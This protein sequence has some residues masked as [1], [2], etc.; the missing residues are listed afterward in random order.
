MVELAAISRGYLSSRPIEAARVL[1]RLDA[2]EVAAF[3]AAVPAP[4]AAAPLAHMAPWKVARCLSQMAPATAAE[5]LARLPA[6]HGVRSLRSLPES[7]REAV[8]DQLPRRRARQ[9]RRQLSY[10]ASLVGAW[11]AGH[12]IALEPEA[13]VGDALAALKGRDEPGRVNV[14]MTGAAGQPIGLVPVAGVLQVPPEQ[15]LA[16]VMRRDIAP[17]PA[18]APLFRFDADR[19][20]RGLLERP[21]VDG[22]GRLVGALSLGQ[23]AAARERTTAD[24]ASGESPAAVVAAGYTAALSGLA[25]TAIGLF[26]RPA[27]RHA[28]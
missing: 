25:R 21:V 1:G 10:P 12:V 4:I 22:R 18:D 23:L 28:R 16:E 15:R 13:T 27:G 3:L 14:Y 8:L 24:V 7:W 19:G 2:A 6:A 5:L 26:T 17:I 11:M 20:W 9:L